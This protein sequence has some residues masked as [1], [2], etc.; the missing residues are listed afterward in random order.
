MQIYSIFCYFSC[1]SVLCGKTQPNSEE[2]YFVSPIEVVNA[3]HHSGWKI[4]NSQ[5][6]VHELLCNLITILEEEAHKSCVDV[7]AIFIFLFNS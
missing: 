5:Q 1:V 2:E 3:L 7:N 6:D 4:T